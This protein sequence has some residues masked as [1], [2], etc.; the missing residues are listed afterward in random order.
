MDPARHTTPASETDPPPIVPEPEKG[1]TPETVQAGAPGPSVAARADHPVAGVD[2]TRAAEVHGMGVVDGPHRY[3]A[4][5]Q[6]PGRAHADMLPPS[7]ETAEAPGR[8]GIAASMPLPPTTH[9]SKPVPQDPK[10]SERT[11]PPV[12]DDRLLKLP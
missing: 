1:G 5:A 2:E 11:A 9:R 8:L 12:P 4:P 10:P 6:S 3:A 7:V